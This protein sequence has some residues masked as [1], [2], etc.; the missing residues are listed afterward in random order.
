MSFG[1][2]GFCQAAYLSFGTA[3]NIGGT[4]FISSTTYSEWINGSQVNWR[5]FQAICTVGSPL[6]GRSQAP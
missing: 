2:S 5:M 1:E 6:S 4:L 3:V